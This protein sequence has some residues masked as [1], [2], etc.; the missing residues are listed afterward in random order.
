MRYSGLIKSDFGGRR[1]VDHR[2]TRE[3]AYDMA[4]P[5]MDLIDGL[6]AIAHGLNDRKRK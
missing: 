4:L 3:L 2:S 1:W 5:A 6:E